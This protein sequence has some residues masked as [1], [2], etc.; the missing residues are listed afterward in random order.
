MPV[1]EDE[2]RELVERALATSGVSAIGAAQAAG[3]NRD[4]IR[5]VLRG[6]SP[7]LGRAAEVCKALGFDFRIIDQRRDAVSAR[8][9]PPEP[10]IPAHAAPLIDPPTAFSR[11][12]ELPVREWAASSPEGWSSPLT[13][14]G[15][16]PAPVGF[17]DP[18]GFYAKTRSDAMRPA[19]IH[20]T[21]F[22]LVSPN[23]SVEAP[24]RVWLR[25]HQGRQTILG[26]IRMTDN[27][28]QLVG[29][30]PP[31]PDDDAYQQMFAANW[32]RTEIVDRGSVVTVYRSLPSVTKP[33]ARGSGWP[34]RRY[35]NLQ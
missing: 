12:R 14:S 16:A 11:D 30:G 34:P 29:W 31:N 4:A 24:Q 25:D 26:L 28:Y 20:P 33:T 1:S 7:S 22:C 23:A 18:A 6:R 13:E 35:T 21:D 5:S 8:E 3:L 15:K 2:F 32:K 9:A 19:G 10:D 27:F 17:E